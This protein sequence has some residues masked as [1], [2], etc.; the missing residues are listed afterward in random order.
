MKT[1]PILFA[2]PLLLSMLLIGCVNTNKTDTDKQKVNETIYEL[3]DTFVSDYRAN[4]VNADNKYLNKT[5]RIEGTI[6]QFMNS[7]GP[8]VLVYVIDL[9]ATV[10]CHF[11]N[12]MSE[13][14]GKLRIGQKVTLKGTFSNMLMAFNFTDC[15]IENVSTAY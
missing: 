11:E 4:S 7:G 12:S 10:H 3:N 8:T 2:L 9:D 15:K 1:K 5:F 14:V 13:E 6:M